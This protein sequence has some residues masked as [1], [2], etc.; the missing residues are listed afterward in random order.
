MWR[1]ISR[2]TASTAVR[3]VEPSARGGVDT[4]M[5]QTSESWT[6]SAVSVVKDRR[7]WR[8]LRATTS[9]SPGS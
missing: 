9:S 2:A 1:P 3:S 5:K 6:A 4:A 7:S 8:T